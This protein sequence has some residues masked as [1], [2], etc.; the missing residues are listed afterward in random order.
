MKISEY[1]TPTIKG[2]FAEFD[3]C[4]LITKVVVTPK[5]ASLSF[6]QDYN[7]DADVLVR[8]N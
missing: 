6:L 8:K 4:E 1:E 2:Q 5:T 3:L 7:I